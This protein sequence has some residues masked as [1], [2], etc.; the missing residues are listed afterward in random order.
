MSSASTNLTPALAAAPEE[1]SQREADQR[2]SRLRLSV[3]IIMLLGVFELIFGMAWDGQ[4]HA[5]VGRDRFFTPPHV[6]MY[7]AVAI[8]GFLCLGMVLAETLRYRRRV[9]GVNDQTT[10]KVLRI[11][12]APLGFIVTGFGMFMILLAAPLDNYWHVLYGID[13]T[14]WSPFHIMG[15]LSGL[16]A[17]LGIVYL[18]GSEA[19]RARQ[20][21][22]HKQAERVATGRWRITLVDFLLIV[23][24]TILLPIALVTALD[25]VQFFQLGPIQFAIYPLVATLSAF[26]LV[27]SVRA[28]GRIGAATLTALIFTLIRL[29]LNFSIMPAVSILAQQEHL[30][31]RASAPHHVVF[32]SVYPAF[33]IVGGL[34][35]DGVYLLLSRLRSN[36]SWL[37]TAAAMLAGALVGLSIALLETPWKGDIDSVSFTGVWLA[38]I[39]LA[40]LVGA[41]WGWLADRFA[42]S[43]RLLD[44]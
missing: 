14:V 23:S 29:G 22:M 18:F 32:V 4:W 30:F 9:P 15:L 27:A 19:T 17:F 13:V 42:I 40:M 28:T 26:V 16:I 39:P 6:L 12:H 1:V 20:R 8:E 33:L 21:D 11:F 43:V 10:S 34:L 3:A 7:S 44:R 31:Y 37:T 41:C 24:L 36:R 38:S 5:A 25:D 35:V 2:E